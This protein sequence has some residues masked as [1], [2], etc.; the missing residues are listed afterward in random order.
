M[1]DVD[2]E[3][4][5]GSGTPFDSQWYSDNHRFDNDKILAENIGSNGTLYFTYTYKRTQKEWQTAL[6]YGEDFLNNYDKALALTPANQS[7]NL[8]DFPGATKIVL[9][10]ANPGRLG[11]EYY[12]NISTAYD[13]ETKKLSLSGLSLSGDPEPYFT[14]DTEVFTPITFSDMLNITAVANNSGKFVIDDVNPTVEATLGGIKTKFR[15]ATSGDT[16]QKYNLTVVNVAGNSTQAGSNDNVYPAERYYL[17]FYTE[18]ENEPQ[19]TVNSAIHYYTVTADKLT[20]SSGASKAKYNTRHDKA[21]IFANIFEQTNVK[22]YTY[23]NSDLPQLAPEEIND[24]NN[25]VFVHLE[26]QIGFT[27]QA[28]TTF[29]AQLSSVD[30]YQNFMV[31]MTNTETNKIGI[32]GNPT[33]SA[34]INVSSVGGTVTPKTYNDS[35]NA[36]TVLNYAEVLSNDSISPYLNDGGAIIVANLQLS[37]PNLGQ[38]TSQFASRSGNNTVEDGNRYTVVSAYSKIGFDKDTVALSKNQETGTI[39]DGFQN[40]WYYIISRKDPTLDY[41]ALASDDGRQFGQLGINANDLPDSTGKVTIETA[42]EFDVR[43]ISSLV[44]ACD[45]VKITFTLQQ[46]KQYTD[47]TFN[48]IV[49]EPLDSGRSIT[50]YLYNVHVDLTGASAPVL[51]SAT[52][53]YTFTVPR[54]SVIALDEKAAAESDFMKIPIVFDVFT[55]SDTPKNSDGTAIEGASSF[56]S[57]NLRYANYK[58][59][60]T[61]QMMNGNASVGAS[62][63]D[64]LVYTN[65]KLLVD[66]IKSE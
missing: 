3:L 55:G 47:G 13:S 38:R 10:D 32:Y 8:T 48:Y 4:A 41:Y 61:A 53:T 62:P 25:T 15:L 63:S 26:S 57:K 1:I 43:P 17:S 36:R 14:N 65:A 37:Y 29:G 51:D 23:A 42:A 64:D 19:E 40:Y 28:S 52:N 7:A 9:V 21:I 11:K 58:V 24:T 59:V 31:Y 30:M 39:K 66:Y 44:A 16:G 45:T 46:K 50:D 49:Y 33:V 20:A 18:R 60:V 12:S 54:S 2:F 5:T 27:S 56:E 22:F 35:T 6:E 34:S